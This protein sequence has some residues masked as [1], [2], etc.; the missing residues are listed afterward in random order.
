MLQALSRRL[1]RKRTNPPTIDFPELKPHQ[2]N[3]ARLFA[4][5]HEMLKYIGVPL[6]GTIAEVGVA[7]GDFSEYI[8]DSLRPFEFVAIDVF[9]MEKSPFHWGIPQSVLFKG[10]THLEF[11]KQRFSKRGKVFIEKGSSHERL[12]T[13]PNGH[14]DLIYIDAAHD[15]DNV[16][17]DG[18]LANIRSRRRG[19]SF[20]MT[21]S[22]MTRFS[23]PPTAW[24]RP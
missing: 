18:V 23:V 13:F 8:L 6:G 20:S 3:G 1:T 14:F 15:Y 10:M 16:K 19:S 17:G 12:A 21:T 4:N 24:S 22:C 11:Y 2:V 9:G 5:R 7:Q